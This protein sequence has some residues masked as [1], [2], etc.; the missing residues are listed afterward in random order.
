MSFVFTS[1]H[2]WHYRSPL[3]ARFKKIKQEKNKKLTVIKYNTLQHL[4]SMLG[5]PCSMNYMYNN[6][7]DALFILSLLSYHTS[8]CFGGISSPSWGKVQ[9]MVQL[10]VS[11]LLT[12]SCTICHI[13]TFYLRRRGCW[14]AW[15]MYRC[16]NSI[17]CRWT[18]H[19][20]GY[21][22]Y[23]TATC[24]KSV[25]AV[26]HASQLISVTVRLRKCRMLVNYI[27]FCILQM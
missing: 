27:Y 23:I 25:Y 4:F 14:N 7:H 24:Q 1:K 13:Y 15:N 26:W 20:V 8:T 2:K 17:N 6:Q 21:Y 10:N 3:T 19:W 18:V 22:T 12:V 16:D 9:Q 11:G 5:W